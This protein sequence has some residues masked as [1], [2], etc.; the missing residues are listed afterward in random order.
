MQ[1]YNTMEEVELDNLL[2]YIYEDNPSATVCRIIDREYEGHVKIPQC[3][4]EDGR[5]YDVREISDFAFKGC[6]GLESIDIP[7]GVYRIG[8]SAFSGCSSLREINIPPSVREIGKRPFEDCGSLVAINVAHSNNYFC[9]INGVLFD[10]SRQVLI[11]YPYAR[12]GDYDIPEGVVKI[13]ANAFNGCEKLDEIYIPPTVLEIG[14]HAF[15]HN[16]AL[17]RVKMPDT[18]LSIR[19]NAFDDCQELRSIDTY[20]SNNDDDDDT[21]SREIGASAF[22]FCTSLESIDIP[23]KIEYI[24]DF[25]F[26]GCTDLKEIELPVTVSEIGECAF[27]NCSKLKNATIPSIVEIDLLMF[28]GCTKLKNIKRN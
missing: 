9:D 2:F 4:W 28:S 16:L 25:A 11:D 22:R 18:L 26:F 23:T 27:N 13:G 10:S 15:S 17:R 19:D 24:G 21:I 20:H 3:I 8:D 1:E 12:S 7:D 6:E 14:D 5:M